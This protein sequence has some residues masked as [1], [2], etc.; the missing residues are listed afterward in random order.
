MIT[1]F[2]LP[3]P[4]VI[5][6]W[7]LCA[8]TSHAESPLQFI[9]TYARQ[10][11]LDNDGFSGFDPARGESLFKTKHGADWSCSSCHTETP[12]KTG[13]HVVTQKLIKPLAPAANPE[14]F[15]NQA[16][17]EKW[18]KRNCKDVLK[19]ECSATEKGDVLTSLLSVH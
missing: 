18:F 6:V 12:E 15:T 1:S 8:G 10:A 19:R 9:D 3:V 5:L 13:T 14:R 7:L 2:Q 16:K 17:V 4:K 11:R